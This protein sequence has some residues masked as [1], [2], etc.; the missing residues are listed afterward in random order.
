MAKN[1]K[2][3]FHRNSENVHLKL[4]GDF[5]GS[6]AYELLDALNNCN[7]ASKVFIH[8]SCLKRIHPFGREVFHNNLNFLN[9]RSAAYLFT[10]EKASQ[11]TPTKNEHFRT[12]AYDIL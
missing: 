8:T 12:I 6:S 11:I 9:N 10:G 1:F 7:R 5:D 3:F 4:F 2:I